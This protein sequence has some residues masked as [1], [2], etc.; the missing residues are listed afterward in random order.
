MSGSSTIGGWIKAC[1]GELTEHKFN[2]VNKEDVAKNL[3]ILGI[4]R[5]AELY[6]HC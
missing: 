3:T 2:T 4:A 1:G 6:E 5:S